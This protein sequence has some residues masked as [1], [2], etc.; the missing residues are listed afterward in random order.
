MLLFADLNPS[1]II[2]PAILYAGLSLPLKIV[3]LSS[4]A[5]KDIL[6]ISQQLN[7][8]NSIIVQ[9][10]KPDSFGRLV[11]EQTV[12]TDKKLIENLSNV[13]KH[14]KFKLI[15]PIKGHLATVD[16]IEV[17]MYKDDVQIGWFRVILNIL[18]KGRD[19]GFHRYRSPDE[20][21]YFNVREAIGLPRYIYKN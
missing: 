11:P 15:L 3:H 7:T 16:R 8:C 4:I 21:F 6:S 1:Y 14:K 18:E 20:Q 19:T 10:R 2:I 5:N 13:I 9:H 17:Y 12:I